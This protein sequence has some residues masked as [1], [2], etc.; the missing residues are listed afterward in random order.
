MYMLKMCVLITLGSVLL[1]F[2]GIFM[3]VLNSP[4][5]TFLTTF[6]GIVVFSFC[7]EIAYNTGKRAASLPVLNQNR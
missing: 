4:G 3:V 5:L 6:T 7:T 2:S 1:M